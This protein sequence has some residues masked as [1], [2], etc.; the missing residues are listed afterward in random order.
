MVKDE[1]CKHAWANTHTDTQINAHVGHSSTDS[2]YSEPEQKGQ[3]EVKG[4]GDREGNNKGVRWGQQ[5]V[6]FA[7]KNR[8]VS[9]WWER[10]TSLTLSLTL[11]SFLHS[12]QIPSPSHSQS[13]AACGRQIKPRRS[14]CLKSTRTI[15]AFLKTDY[16]T[17]R[18]ISDKEEL[19]SFLFPLMSRGLIRLDSA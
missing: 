9:N 15:V 6:T 8:S 12:N 2:G 19:G 11:F 18:D 7:G 1:P 5:L 3:R 4:E 10:L 13:P 16:H 17:T 14:A